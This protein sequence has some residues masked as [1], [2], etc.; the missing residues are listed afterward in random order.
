MDK[1]AYILF[2][3]NASGDVI[4][5]AIFTSKVK[6]YAYMETYL[7]PQ[8]MHSEGWDLEELQINPTEGK[9]L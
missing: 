8:K 7:T 6:L 9:G 5:H 4:F 2:T 3:E 1:K